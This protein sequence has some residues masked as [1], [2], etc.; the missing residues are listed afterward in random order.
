MGRGLCTACVFFK[1]QAIRFLLIDFQFFICI[2]SDMVH[3]NWLN[4]HFLL[5]DIFC[6]FVDYGA[7]WLMGNRDMGL[8]WGRILHYVCHVPRHALIGTFAFS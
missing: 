5:W 6:L 4:I 8:V 3:C 7:G 1:R 2:Y